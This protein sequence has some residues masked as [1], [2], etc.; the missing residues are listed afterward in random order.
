MFKNYLKIAYRYF[1]GHKLFSF[2]N[3]FGLAIGIS[4]CTIISLWVQRELSYDRFHKN[5]HRIYRIERE[6]FRD[7]AYSRWPITGGAYKQALI[8]DFPEIENAVRF[9]GREFSIKDNKNFVHRKGM[10][11]VDNS[12]FEIFDFE[13]EKGDETTALIKPRS[14]VLTRDNA[15][16][17]LGTDD[18]IGKSLSFEWEGEQV[19]FEITGILK[20]VP[21]NSHVQFDMLIS[22]SSYPNDRFS[23][24]RSNYL[25]T[26][27]LASENTT[28][29]DLEE[30][31]KTFVSNRLEP[32][33]GDLLSQGLG[34]H[35]VLKM[36]LFPITDIHL[37]PS[38]N[39]EIGAGGSMTSVYIFSSIAIL[40]LIIACINFM[41]LST[42][43]ANKR[44][45]EV[46]LRKTIGAH[47]SQLRMQFIQE[48]VLLAV[49][50]LFVAIALVSLFIPAYNKI[51]DDTLSMN[52]LLLSKNLIMLIGITLVVGFLAGLY[53]AF[54]L[55]KFEAA[56]ILKSSPMLGSGKSIFRRNMVVVQF[57]ISITLIIGT[58]TVYEQ[59]KYIQTK[60]LGF[61]KENV[62]L[63]PVRSQQIV[64]SYKSFRNE[65]LS[66]SQIQSLAVSSDLPGET[67]YSN[68]NF[69]S[70][71]QANDPVMTIVLMTDYDFV[72]TYG[73]EV[74]AGRSFS[75]E[76]ISDT[77][78]TIMLNEAAVQRFG[79]DPQEAIGKDLSF[80][81][82]TVGKIVG[83]VKDFNFRSLH[84]KV[85]PMALILAPNYIS[86][87]SVRIQ[88]GNIKRTID[89]IQQ[90]WES[91]FPGE[92]FEFSFLDNRMNQ[93]YENEMKMQ[94]IFIIFSCFSIFVACLG[95]FG[96]SVF[97]AAERTKEIGIRK[98][99]G[100]SIGKIILLLSKEFI[101]WII[102]A[103]IVA[104]PF[105]WFIMN[106]WL[107]N[108]AYRVDIGIWIFILSASLALIIALITVSYQSIKAAV[109]NPVE[110]LRY[111]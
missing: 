42:A 16:K 56:G 24:W 37:Y 55:T 72:G 66:H 65:L 31:L 38:P 111:E 61:D 100:A 30:K 88:P 93:L 15:L 3:V 51:F 101:A 60:S 81:R 7:N 58:L 62:I 54:Y 71:E 10:F 97:I 67:F 28:R 91:T 12:I 27:I 5:A 2:I 22:I 70:R 90:K 107:Q 46:G 25:F 75:R 86:A 79:W 48:S 8:D 33:Y 21:Q 85:E 103:N 77:S 99:L 104:W 40:I 83:V 52:S 19:D 68:T 14:V 1:T 108:F 43:G 84:T 96:L 49:I 89:F 109:A 110:S 102:I 39:W 34:I 57:I 44:A 36:H 74:V 98:V 9:W 73:M 94:N 82:G 64:Q 92:L 105:A 23:G 53:P 87:I 59:M 41:N 69:A 47:K 35:E 106:K 45:K 6:L 63:L 29:S 78:G 4:T 20:E 26:Y 13:L 11:A 80:F 50:A 32:H 95:L 17:F 76:F 18:V